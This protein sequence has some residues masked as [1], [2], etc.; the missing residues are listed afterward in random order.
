MFCDL[1]KYYYL[2]LLETESYT[3]AQ[4]GFKLLPPGPPALA[5]QVLGLKMC[6]HDWLKQ[7]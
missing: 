3:V 1:G 4:A 2:L 7:I 6:Y 5:S